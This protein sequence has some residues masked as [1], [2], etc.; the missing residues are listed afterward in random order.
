MRVSPVVLAAVAVLLGCDDGPAP[1]ISV[2]VFPLDGAH[3][4]GSGFAIEAFVDGG[5]P[6]AVSFWID[7]AEAFSTDEPPDARNGYPFTWYAPSA[8]PEGAHRFA[9]KALVHGLAFASPPRGFVLDRTAPEL[10][11]VTPPATAAVCVSSVFTFAFSE[12]MLVPD[13]GRPPITFALDDGGVLDATF[14]LTEGDRVARV[15]LDV[16]DGG[17]LEAEYRGLLTATSTSLLEDLAGNS[18]AS[19]TIIWHVQP[20]ATR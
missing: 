19:F 11:A 1:P 20:C 5:V 15:T 13:V 16:P 4:N 6:S 9:A 18:I 12:A 8:E 14:A 10:T 3:T 2:T 7:D 17:P